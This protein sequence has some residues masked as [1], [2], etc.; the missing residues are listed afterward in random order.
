MTKTG[1]GKIT[2]PCLCGCG[3][4]FDKWKSSP[5]NFFSRAC[6]FLWRKT[7]KGDPG[8]RKKYESCKMAAEKQWIKVRMKASEQ[9]RKTIFTGGYEN[10]IDLALGINH[11]HSE[12]CIL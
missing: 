5:R 6:L 1:Q 11:G 10:E 12:G 3:K 9:H 7:H 2:L 4:K 8:I